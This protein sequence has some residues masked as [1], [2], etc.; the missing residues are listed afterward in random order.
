[1]QYQARL[2]TQLLSSLPGQNLAY[3]PKSLSKCL[4]KI[5]Y[6]LQR[7]LHRDT[8]RRD[9]HLQGSARH[10][11]NLQ[12]RQR[13]AAHGPQVNASQR[14]CVNSFLRH[15]GILCNLPLHTS[16]H[17]KITKTV[18]NVNANFS[19]R[20]GRFV[21]VGVTREANRIQSKVSFF[22]CITIT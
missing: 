21:L 4:T 22:S 2:L 13:R 1:M 14:G 11:V 19:C 15:G 7:H 6:P 5:T 10:G 20:D 9:L 3:L 12:R 8:G 16:I 17:L 18:S